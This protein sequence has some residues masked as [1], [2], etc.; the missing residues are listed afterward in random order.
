MCGICRGEQ[1]D[2]ISCSRCNDLTEILDIKKIKTL[3]C[4]YCPRLTRILNMRDINF[5]Y[6]SRC[7]KLNKISNIKKLEMLYCFNCPYLVKI[8]NTKSLKTVY[9][10]GCPLLYIP[11]EMELKVD[12]KG[13]LFYFKLKKIIS[14]ARRRIKIRR[15]LYKIPIVNDVLKYV[16]FK[17]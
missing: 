12:V 13:K 16:I 14:R 9:Y 8:S 4:K 11:R 2:T 1:R 17:Y 15:I 5:L 6:C 3:Y 10:D 7:Y